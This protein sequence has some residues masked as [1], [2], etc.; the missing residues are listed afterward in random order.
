[1]SGEQN[2]TQYK[3]RILLRTVRRALITAAALAALPLALSVFLPRARV[4]ALGA[5]VPLLYLLV[6]AYHISAYAETLGVIRDVQLINADDDPATAAAIVFT[7]ID[8]GHECETS[9]T[10]THYG[11][12]V[13]GCEDELA[14][15]LAEDRKKIG[16][17]VPVLYFRQNPGTNIIYMEDMQEP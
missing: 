8:T 16:M 12:Y 11:D 1:M 9:R 2:M 5:L 13:E 15:M 3:K 6:R 4:L 10:I 14:A 7:D 17:L